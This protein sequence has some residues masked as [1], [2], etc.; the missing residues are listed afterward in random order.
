MP[1]H[2]RCV[3]GR[4]KG[5]TAMPRRPYRRTRTFTPSEP[6]WSRDG[7][8]VRVE[9]A[10]H[11][12]RLDELRARPQRYARWFAA[13]RRHPGHATCRCTREGERLVIRQVAGVDHL[14]RWPRTRD[15]HRPGCPFFTVDS[16]HAS[17]DAAARAAITVT[18]HGTRIAVGY[19]FTT[20]EDLGDAEDDSGDDEPTG[21][22]GGARPH[23]ATVTGLG[24][25]HWLFEASGLNTWPPTDAPGS[26]RP[27]RG[28]AD[29]HAAL[30]E[31]LAGLRLGAHPAPRLAY[32]VAPY[33]PGRPEPARDARLA[34]FLRPLEHLE[35]VTIRGGPRRGHTRTLRHRRL[36]CG[37]LKDL[38]DTKH[39]H[40]LTLHHFPRPIFSP[41]DLATDLARRHPPRSRP[42]GAPPPGGSYS[43]WSRP[44]HA[45]TCAWSTPRCC[46][47]APTTSRWTP[48]TS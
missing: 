23:T 36:L 26:Q 40:K 31:V 9:I 7:F 44:P 46:S 32:V 25:L 37:E 10:G 16:R 12:V 41:D 13:A 39:G 11:L 4:L 3:S 19:A 47:P 22:L 1:P 42:A 17:A 5:T 38:T 20:T 34:E 33:R 48:A 14:A 21:L 30:V 15:N 27:R 24:L 8:G 29:V 45:A 28:W 2:S 6:S 18:E 35:Q 43:P